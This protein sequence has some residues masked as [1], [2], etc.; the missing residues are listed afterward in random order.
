MIYNYLHDVL[1]QLHLRKLIRAIME[2]NNFSSG[3]VRHGETSSALLRALT[4]VSK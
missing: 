4:A 2:G 3:W 1:L